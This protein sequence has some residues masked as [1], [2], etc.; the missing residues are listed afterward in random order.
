MVYA[1]GS[2]DAVRNAQAINMNRALDEAMNEFRPGARTFIMSRSGS[3]GMQRHGASVWSGDVAASFDALADQPHLAQSMGLVG[4]PYWNSDIGGFNGT[5]SPELYLRWC[6]FGLFN[7]VYRP[8]GAGSNREPWRFGTEVEGH[9]RDLLKLRSRLVPYYYTVARE[10]WDTGAPIMRP[11][12]M[13]WPDDPAVRNLDTQFLYGPSLLTRPVTSEGATFADVYLP[14]GTWTDWFTGVVRTGPTI[15]FPIVLNERFPLFVRTPTIL[16][17]GPEVNRSD[18]APLDLLTL[19][20]FWDDDHTTATGRLYE[21][22]GLTLGYQDG[23]FAWSHFE[24]ERGPSGEITVTINPPASAA[25]WLPGTRA[26]RVEIPVAGLPREVRANGSP[27]PWVNGPVQD[28]EQP[29]WT[30]EPTGGRVEVLTSAL[31]VDAP[32]TIVLR[33]VASS[34]GWMLF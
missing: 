7:P 29:G 9:V 28:L 23:D 22:D 8:H 21:D 15:T 12:V 1:G 18:A 33:Q 16:P 30:L 25:P 11:L 13:D 5:P 24:A 19:R 32:V 17:L 34:H 27:L 10:A 26:Y 14:A 4:V 31:P 3:P 2:A 20:V 6:Q